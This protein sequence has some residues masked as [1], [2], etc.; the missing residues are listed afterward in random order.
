MIQNKKD[1][2]NCLPSYGNDL[3]LH[4]NDAK[5]FSANI[6]LNKAR[7]NGLV[8]LSKAWN[9]ANGTLKTVQQLECANYTEVESIPCW[10]LNG[11][12]HTKQQGIE[13]QKPMTEPS[14]CIIEP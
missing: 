11:F 5:S 1:I 6:D 7:V 8:E 3:N 10:T 2:H 4:V 14:P 9:K 13:P 12:G